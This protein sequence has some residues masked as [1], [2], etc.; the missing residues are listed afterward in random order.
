MSYYY[1]NKYSFSY[2][3]LNR[4][5]ERLSLSDLNDL[6][7]QAYCEKLINQASDVIITSTHKYVK[8]NNIDLYFIIE[9]NQ[10]LVK[11]ICPLSASKLLQVIEDDD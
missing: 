5:R 2:H 10:N 6:G 9:K 7:L 4:I 3:A 8:I 11:T 1:K